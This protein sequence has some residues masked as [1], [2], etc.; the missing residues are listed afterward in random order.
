MDLYVD[1]L[2]TTSR[3]VLALCRHDN[4]EISVHIISLMKGEHHQ[5]PFTELNPNRLVPVLV[6]EEFVLTESSAILRYLARL[7]GS[8]L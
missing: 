8:S 6:D 2:G 4:I 5:L 3:A 7:H 1:P